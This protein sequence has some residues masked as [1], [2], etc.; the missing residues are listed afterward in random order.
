M[1]RQLGIA[2]AVA[3]VS[4]GV[5]CAPATAAPPQIT[6][7]SVAPV[8]AQSVHRHARLPKIVGSVGPEY[9]IKIKPQKVPAGTYRLVVH[10]RSEMHN[11]H[12]FRHGIDKAT[13]V[14]F[15]GKKVWKLT[16][17]KGRYRIQCDPHPLAMR[18]H[19][20]VT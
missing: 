2:I 6:S 14:P 16:F 1:R 5:L 4:S 20:K 8:A 17:V 13:T 9:V 12:I 3:L 19:L 11:F 7:A 10:D 15:V 18:T